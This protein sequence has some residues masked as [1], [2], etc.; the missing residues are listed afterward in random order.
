MTQ[1]NK[2][3][4]LNEKGLDYFGFDEDENYIYLAQLTDLDGVYVLLS[5]DRQNEDLLAKE[6]LFVEFNFEEEEDN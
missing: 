6:E 2:L 5:M 4:K 3:V 1:A